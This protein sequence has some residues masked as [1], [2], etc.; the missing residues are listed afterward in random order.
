MFI[1]V[2]IVALLAYMLFKRIVSRNSARSRGGVNHSDD[3]YRRAPIHDD[4]G[5]YVSQP[6]PPAYDDL[7]GASSTNRARQTQNINRDGFLS[8]LYKGWRWPL[9]GLGGLSG[10]VFWIVGGI[11]RLTVTIFRYFFAKR[12]PKTYVIFSK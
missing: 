11:F 1:V 9:S 3:D 12:Q 10:Y 8:A 5:D 2:I 6:P 4:D 7:F